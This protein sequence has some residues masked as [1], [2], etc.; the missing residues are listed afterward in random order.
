MLGSNGWNFALAVATI[1][2]FGC[3]EAPSTSNASDGVPGEGR[4][5]VRQDLLSAHAAGAH[6]RYLRART[7]PVMEHLVRTVALALADDQLRAMVRSAVLES[8]F[9]EHKVDFD[10]F[11]SSTGGRLLDRVSAL[12]ARTSA[13]VLSELAEIFPLEM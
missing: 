13:A 6:R 11:I 5:I 7:D 12:D 1:G 3:A 8:P 4:G 2:L 9:R 10:Q